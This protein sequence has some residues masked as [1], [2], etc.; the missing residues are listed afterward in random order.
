M[1]SR[2][3][4]ARRSFVILWINTVTSGTGGFMP[5]NKR[6]SNG[7]ETFAK[8]Q[9]IVYAPHPIQSAVGAKSGMNRAAGKRLLWWLRHMPSSSRLDAIDSYGEYHFRVCT[10]ERTYPYAVAEGVIKAE[11]NFKA[12][13]RRTTMKKCS[14]GMQTAHSSRFCPSC[15][16][17][18]Q[19]HTRF[20]I[21]LFLGGIAGVL[22]VRAFFLDP[23]EQFGWSMF[24]E[25]IANGQIMDLGTVVGSAT[26]AKCLAGLVLGAGTGSFLASRSNRKAKAVSDPKLTSGERG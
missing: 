18:Y 15:G 8:W 20:L 3:S 17:E 13:A 1:C 5:F 7:S 6:S 24:W 26:F 16:K 22:L 14:C 12:Y 10:R 23:F 19:S 9:T 2:Y 21:W 11:R 4:R 25:G